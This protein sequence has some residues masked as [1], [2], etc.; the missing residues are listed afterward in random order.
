M[1]TAKTPDPDYVYVGF[2]RSLFNAPTILII[3]GVIHALITLTIYHASGDPVYIVLAVA[4]LL[5]GVYRFY[6]IRL[7]QLA[8]NIHDMDTARDWENHYLLG[9]T[10]QA[11]LLGL[12]C[13]ATLYIAPV[14]FGE[15]ASVAVVM[16]STVAIVGRNYGSRRMVTIQAIAVVGPIGAG[17]MLQNDA[18]Y[19]LLGL[20]LIPYI[21]V[22]IRMAEHVRS[23]L[24]SALVEER[25]ARKLAQRFDRALNTMGH[26]LIMLGADG[27][28]AVA[29]AEAAKLAGFS[30][31]DKMLGRSLRSLLLRGVAAGL[32][33]R[34]DSRFINLQI[35]GAIG[36]MQDRKVQI[37]LADGRHFELTAR[38][39]TGDLGVL[40]FE[41][42]TQR[43]E[44]EQRIR[45]MARYD[46]LTDL[47]N[48]G[49]F[50]EVVSETVA[51]G[52]RDRLCGIAVM[53]LDDFKSVNDTLGHPV[54]DGL[55][56]AVA[57]KL[58]SYAD[59]N[60]KV[61]RFGGDEFTVFFN[62]IESEAE[63]TTRLDAMLADLRGDIDVAGHCVRVVL[64]CGAVLGRA[65]EFDVDAMLVNADLAL[66]NAKDAGKN[67]WR[68]FEGFMDQAFRNRQVMKADL[69]SA[70]ESKLLR[71]VFQP[72]IS[73]ETMRITSCEALCR[74]DHPE[75]GPIS[76]AI[77]VPLAEE[78]GIVGDI[79]SF[80]LEAAC[81]QCATWPEHV[82]VSV[83][84]SAKDFKN[85]EI[86]GKI[87]QVLRKN[88]LRPNR[89]EIEVTETALLE[90]KVSTFRYIN[91]LKQLGVS[92]ALDDFG[93]GYSSLS[94]LH[95]L[96]LDK[97]KIDRS[98]LA[99]ITESQRSLDLVR[100]VVELSRTLGLTVTVEG[101]ETFEQLRVLHRLVKPDLVQGFL[102]GSPLSAAGIATMSNT[103][104]PFA[105]Q[106]VDERSS[107]Y[108]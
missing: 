30:S 11:F 84:L 50:H 19:F 87:A 8:N 60:V 91:E 85:D 106:L 108:S 12:L 13:F 22:L 74:W 101:V 66:Y 72:I 29:N 79:S 97:V 6:G 75:M 3:G 65:G 24:F 80:I 77:F 95:S 76:P 99:D 52:K 26:G 18:H 89:L 5:A 98:F 69:R 67:Q 63:L 57:H 36:H 4:L 16:G 20:C 15:L 41:E 37:G 56:V 38:E 44:A 42:I 93:T 78:M 31:K 83:N 27:R 68:L 7:G 45:H 90:D 86:V 62:C 32:L 47:P 70:I 10:L 17:L 94:Y 2:V 53:D 39:G 96:P 100:G 81:A 14:P 40:T 48:R 73:M 21:Y 34:A 51:S 54:G 58:A 35:F 9:G 43:V 25:K 107:L 103:T 28:V 104:W 82:S 92:V 71:A 102:F 1:T 49:Y 105:S 33:S 46:R 55:I 23:V 61:G 59:D 88:K 64:S